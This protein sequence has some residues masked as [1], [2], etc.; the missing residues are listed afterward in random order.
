MGCCGWREV[1]REPTTPPQLSPGVRVV[2]R[3]RSEAAADL[4]A[5]TGGA[6]RCRTDASPDAK[7]AEGALAA[8]AQ[9]HRTA[10]RTPLQDPTGTALDLLEAWIVER[11]NAESMGRDERDHRDGGIAALRSVLADLEDRP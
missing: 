6:S 8:I 1:D 4:V 2:E 7:R 10:K 9:L 3:H 11:A 5:A